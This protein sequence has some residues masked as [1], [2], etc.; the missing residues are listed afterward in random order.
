MAKRNDHRSGNYENGQCRKSENHPKAAIAKLIIENLVSPR[1]SAFL[2]YLCHS[3]DSIGR[4][5]TRL[6]ICL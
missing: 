1:L 2:G 6:F 4:T 3:Y 5:T